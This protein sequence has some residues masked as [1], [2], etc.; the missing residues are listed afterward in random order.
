[1]SERA[2]GK[3][4]PSN[5]AHEPQVVNTEVERSQQPD[6]QQQQDVPHQMAQNPAVHISLSSPAIGHLL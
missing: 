3:A 6:R 4:E 5:V 1:M 2:S